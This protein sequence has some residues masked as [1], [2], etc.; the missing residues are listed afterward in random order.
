MAN[1][2]KFSESIMKE[3]YKI[4]LK[5]SKKSFVATGNLSLIH[6]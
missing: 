4:Y 3:L 6:I 2:L 1:G 5:D